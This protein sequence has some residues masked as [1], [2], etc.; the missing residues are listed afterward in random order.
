MDIHLHLDL[1]LDLVDESPRPSTTPLCSSLTDIL[2]RFNEDASAMNQ[3]RLKKSMQTCNTC[4]IRKVRCN[5]ARPLCSNC[6]RLGFP[7][8]Y[9][10]GQPPSRSI[11]LPRRRVRQACL[12]CHGRKARCSGHWPACERCRGLG[13]DCVYRPGKRAR[14]SAS[15]SCATDKSPSPSECMATRADSADTDHGDLFDTGHPRHQSVHQATWIQATPGTNTQ[16]L[17]SLMPRI[18][19]SFFRHIHHIPTCSFLHRASLMAQY[20]H[21]N[22][23]KALLLAI[24][25]ITSCLMDMGPGMQQFGHR[26]AKDSEMLILA[27]YTRP[28]IFKIQALVLIIKHRIITNSFSSAFILLSVASRFAAVLRLNH[29]S[30]D[31]SFLAQESRRRLMWSLYCIDAAISGGQRDYRLWNTPALHIALPCNERNFEFDLPKHTE[32]LVSNSQEPRLRHTEDIGSLA[33]HIRILH[34]RQKIVEFSKDTL[35]VA[36]LNGP[37]FEASVAA[38][39]QELD[40]FA[41]RLPTSFQFSQSSLR[42]RAYSPRI[43]V[44]VMIHVWW[45]QCHCD[46]YR[47][48]LSGFRNAL[49]PAMVEGLDGTFWQRCRQQCLDHSL[50]M[51][52]IFAAMKH[53]NATMVA[54]LDLALCAHQCARILA[55][56]LHVDEGTLG[57]KADHVTEQ[58]RFCLWAVQSCCKGPS[59]MEVAMEINALIERGLVLD[60][61]LPK[62]IHAHLDNDESLAQVEVAATGVGD[63]TLLNAMISPLSATLFNSW[64]QGRSS[65]DSLDE[66]E[67]AECVP[68]PDCDTF[69]GASDLFNHQDI[70]IEGVDVDGANWAWPD[71]LKPCAG[72]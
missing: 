24:V 27:D 7:C 38:L 71:F 30:T 10:D 33:L 31:L 51:A 20:A 63:E 18:L 26:C 66:G 29:E 41:N 5:G 48:G 36:R 72:L 59:A 52:R 54:D 32:K 4:R 55:H 39:H 44:F 9:A 43:C 15:A 49:T 23:G 47:L 8:S 62:D 6:Q 22:V 68:E 58:V 3:A 14:L 21:G 50:A 40:E 60:A 42:L 17:D 64:P 53:L 16:F 56:A 45:H 70:G 57:L 12:T 34:I 2:Y 11:V 67:E 46:L 69:Q 37:D 25:A 13:L 61:L 28:S 65:L 35:A 1:D 19:D